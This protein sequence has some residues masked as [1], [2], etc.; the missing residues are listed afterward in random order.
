MKLEDAD[1][2]VAPDLVRRAF[3]HF[4]LA[5]LRELQ[6]ESG[7]K[8]STRFRQWQLPL[9]FSQLRDDLHTPTDSFLDLF[10]HAAIFAV[11]ALAMR[12]DE[13]HHSNDTHL[14][15]KL[16]QQKMRRNGAT[17]S[18][19]P[20]HFQPTNFNSNANISFPLNS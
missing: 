4:N 7:N 14:T 18:P 3:D 13:Q 2:E 8:K 10:S 1:A 5:T 11:F 19:G 6:D 15:Y 12:G 17:L 16:F 9:T 20:N